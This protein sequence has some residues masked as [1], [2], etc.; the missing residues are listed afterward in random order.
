MK[1]CLCLGAEKRRDNTGRRCGLHADREA[2]FAAGGQTPV[3]YGPPL[4]LP[5]ARSSFFCHGIRQWR[6]PNV[7]NSTG[8]KI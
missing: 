3:S 4:M 8:P 1:V 6:R 5:D 2:D 7:S